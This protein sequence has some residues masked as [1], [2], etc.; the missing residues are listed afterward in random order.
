[1]EAARRSASVGMAKTKGES[2]KAAC[3]FCASEHTETIEID[4]D[5]WAVACLGCKA[6]GPMGKSKEL[7]ELRWNERMLY[8]EVR[9]SA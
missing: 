4:T 2:M 6:I 9:K 7:A 8:A 5:G 1:M 3:P